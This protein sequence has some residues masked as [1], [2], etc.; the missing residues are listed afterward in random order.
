MLLPRLRLGFSWLLFVLLWNCA[1]AASGAALPPADVIVIHAHIYT[2]NAQ[3]KWADAMAIGGGR[4]LAVGDMAK[5]DA[6]RGN[7]TRII[8]AQ[9]RLVL[10][11]FTDSH[12]HFIEGALVLQHVLLDDAKNVEEIQ[13]RVKE[14]A[15]AH[16]EKTWI[17]GRGWTYPVFAPSGLPDKKYLDQIVPDRPVY[18]Q[19]FDG[20]TWW[21][22][23]KALQLAGITR[24]TPDPPGGTI[25]R[26]PRTGE[27][28]GVIKED[29]ADELMR[30]VIPL[31][32]R[33]ERLA[34]FRAGLRQA[35]RFGLVR[36]HC[37]GND[38]IA[39]SDLG[40]ADLLEELFKS[41]ELTVRFYLAYRV[42]PPAVTARQL[43]EIE[44]A[45]RRYHDEWISAG[46]VKFFLDGVVESHT[47]AMLAPYTD[48]PAQ[49]GK[50]FWDPDNYKQAVAELDKRGIQILTHAIGDK[51]VRLALDAY[52]NAAEVNH[53]KDVRPRIEHIETIS[54][55]DIDRFGKLGVIASMQPL[56]SY[57]DDDTLGIWARNIGP[58]RA[59]RAWV[60]RSIE[61]KGGALAFGSDWP[62]VTLNPWP[63]VQTAL[64][65]QTAEGEPAG[66]FVPQ[67]RLSLEDTIRAY[68]LG[69][70]F[71]GRREKTEGSLE[72][73]KLADFI[74]LDRDLFRIEPSEIGKTEV[75]LTM[76]GGKVVYESPNWKTSPAT[77]KK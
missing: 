73:G 67:Q 30:R 1:L 47:A 61:Q 16:P 71:A 64:T 19:A 32:A 12:I 68:T 74:V 23:S 6:Y 24:K 4:I 3:Q 45:R 76:V 31:P 75:L 48:D 39:E 34:A 36:V 17:L 55:Q 56:H 51:A 21:A 26:D 2:V 52:Q 44:A 72:P 38:S 69:A 59:S 77:E 58:E 25:V 20:H 50:L 57:P 9:G 7:T 43:E 15:T 27:A 40:N 13:R 18:L 63:G 54:A 53:T 28:T 10:P 41:G 29:A 22:N 66:G 11:G 42:N 46:S 37:A 33:Q 5:V 49:S 35:S 60:W 14:Y 8:D 70:A 65:R 62:V